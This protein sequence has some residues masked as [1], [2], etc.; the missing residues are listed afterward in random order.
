MIGAGGV[1]LLMVKVSVAAPVPPELAALKLTLDVPAVVGV[2]EIMPVEVSTDNP[3][4]SPVA[5]KLVGPLL[6]V[7][8]KLK[9]L[10]TVPLALDALLMTGAGGAVELPALLN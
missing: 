8:V 2:P 7:I 9:A 6:A 3:P 10:P 4:G 1:A 5:L